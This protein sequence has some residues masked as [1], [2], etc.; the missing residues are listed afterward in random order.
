M[1]IKFYL[2][3]ILT[4]TLFSSCLLAREITGAQ[5][6]QIVAGA[7]K[8]NMGT[9]SE[10]PDYI[11]FR[12]ES[13]IAFADFD[14]WAH[15]TFSLSSDYGFKLLTTSNDQLGMTHYRYRQTFQGHEVEATMFIVHVK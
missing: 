5:A 1:K 8:V 7:E 14:S 6:Q 15:Q 4:F 12:P 3:A 13:R 9:I 2:S 10:I 11:Q